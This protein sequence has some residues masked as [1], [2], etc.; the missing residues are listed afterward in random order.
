MALS[1]E[2][3]TGSVKF[4]VGFY[5][6]LWETFVSKHIDSQQIEVATKSADS[7]HSAVRRREPLEARQVEQASRFQLWTSH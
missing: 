2:P 3:I 6:R 4:L 7:K 5:R 1:E